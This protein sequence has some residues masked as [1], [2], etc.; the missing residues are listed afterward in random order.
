MVVYVFLIFIAVYIHLVFV[1]RSCSF[2]CTFL[3]ILF[4]SEIEILLSSKL[5]RKKKPKAY[6]IMTDIVRV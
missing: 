6:M 5:E 4:S 2:S 3:L 1:F